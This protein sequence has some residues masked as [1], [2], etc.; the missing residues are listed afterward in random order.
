[1]NATSSAPRATGY[2]TY[3]INKGEHSSNRTG[4]AKLETDHLKFVVKFDSS[5]IYTS[6]DPA[7][8]HDIN[9]LF[10]FSDNDAHHHQFSARIGWNWYNNALHVYAYVYNNGERSSKYIASVPLNEPITCGIKSTTNAYIFTV[11][12]KQVITSR[13]STTPHAKGYFLFPY[14][15][16]DETAPHDISIAIKTL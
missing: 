15:G 1:M 7:N 5:A 3:T 9:K 14:F 12:D 4:P 13:S 10:G 8:Q 2:T 11:D 6:Q 16:G